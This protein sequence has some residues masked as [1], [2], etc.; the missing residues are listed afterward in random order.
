[1]KVIHQYSSSP[2]DS[3]AAL[4]T[5]IIVRSLPVAIKPG[6]GISTLM[7]QNSDAPLFGHTF[8]NETDDDQ[9]VY[10]VEQCYGSKGL[11]VASNASG[12]WINAGPWS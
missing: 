11:Y 5:E 2:A 10:T 3:D 4:D 1:M 9:K 12:T 8:H 6:D 7:Q